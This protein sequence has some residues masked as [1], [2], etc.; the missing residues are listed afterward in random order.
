MKRLPFFLLCAF[1]TVL[2][3]ETPTEYQPSAVVA[4]AGSAA[5]SRVTSSGAL[6]AFSAN[7]AQVNVPGCNNDDGLTDIIGPDATPP[8]SEEDLIF[9]IP[10]ISSNCVLGAGP[11]EHYTVLARLPEGIAPPQQPVVWNF[12][13]TGFPC[14]AS[15]ET[16]NFTTQ[17]EQRITP[18]GLVKLVCHFKADG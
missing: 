14:F 4:P 15:T 16:L 1:V 11:T 8:F 3:C 12:E 7:G 5:G 2:G 17:W 13:N 6:Q 18:S 9:D 10:I